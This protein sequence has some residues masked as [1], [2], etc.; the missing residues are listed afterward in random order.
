MMASEMSFVA[1]RLPLRR[2][3]VTYFIFNVFTYFLCLVQ[4]Q[5]T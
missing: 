4:E 1:S 2:V 3:F 5:A